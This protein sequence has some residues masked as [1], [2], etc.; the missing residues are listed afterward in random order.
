MGCLT[1]VCFILGAV[2]LLVME[3]PLIFWLIVVPLTVI[4]GV[5][6]IGWLLR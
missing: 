1:V 4:G 3:Y 5:S 6:F 2:A